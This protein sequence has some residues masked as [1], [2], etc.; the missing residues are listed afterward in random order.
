MRGFPTPLS[1]IGRLK[2]VPFLNLNKVLELGSGKVLTTA[3]VASVTE[4][5]LCNA[6]LL[7]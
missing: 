4:P 6:A 7:V 1:Q 2:W 5:C 3:K